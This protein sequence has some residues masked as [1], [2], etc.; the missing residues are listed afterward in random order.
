M[1]R[2]FLIFS[3]LIAFTNFATAQNLTVGTSGMPLRELKSRV[4]QGSSYFHDQFVKSDVVTTGG[5]HLSLEAIR[6]NILNQQVEYLSKDVVYE[7]QDSLQSFQ[8]TDSSGTSHV[9]EKQLLN[10]KPYFFEVLA[11]GKLG[12]LKRYTAKKSETEDWYTKKKVQSVLRRPEYYVLKA[13]KVEH[14]S[15]SK[16][17]VQALFTDKS[18]QVKSYLNNN[19]PDFKSDDSLKELFEFYNSLN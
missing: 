3:I 1:Q 12:L 19:S 4:E 6:Y 10:G 9:L 13:G 8:V 15:P 16:K 2:I 11:S 18:D 14:F 5:K 7:V 17:N